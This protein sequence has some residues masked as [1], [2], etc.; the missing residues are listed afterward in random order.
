M[1][2]VKKDK[3]KKKPFKAVGR[4]AAGVG[5]SAKRP[6][7]VEKEAPCQQFCASR[8]D[9]RAWLTLI[10][11]R[12]K[13]GT[14]EEE[15]FTKAFELLTDSNPFP[16]IMGRVCPHPCEDNCNRTDKDGGVAINS[17][18]RFLG[19]WALE[20]G[21]ALKK[22]DEEKK[23]ESIGVIGAGPSGLS[24]AFQMARRGYPVT[25]YEANEIAGGML[26]YGIPEYRLPRDILQG[27]I[28]RVTD[29]GVEIKLNTKVGKDV[30]LSDLR[31]QHKVMFLAI[32]AHKG[33]SMR[34]EGEDFDGV[35]GGV[36][37]LNQVN[38]GV[39]V[40]VG[41]KVVVI[42]GGDT[43]IDAARMA[44][45][46]GADVNIVYRRT[47]VEMPAIESEIEDALKE[48]V[49]IDYLAAPVSVRQG[50]EG[51]RL[52]FKVQKMELGEPD[53]S[54]RRRPVPIE[55]SEYDLHVDTVI[56][57]ISQAPDWTPVK[58]YQPKKWLEPDPSGRIEDDTWAGG[59]VVDLGIAATA[60]FH[61]RRAAERVHTELRG[62][63][64]PPLDEL[65]SIGKD[66][67]RL[68][69]YDPL[70]R[71]ERAHRPVEEWLEKP[72]DEIDHGITK[73]QFLEEAKRCLSCGSCFGCERCWMYCTPS[74]IVK[75]E[76]QAPG[77]YYTVKL[78]LCDGC[79]KCAEE[80]PCGFW[81]MV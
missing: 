73:D 12:D 20:K 35:W 7:Q 4:G 53:S 36:E 58:E 33:K 5:G 41:K 47:R 39:K 40:N 2:I 28:D 38:R 24:F 13:T 26:Y 37:Y 30:L 64:P 54:G 11:Q 74:A 56:A 49:Q 25:V 1:P 18:E 29:V 52:T 50:T 60:V 62:M 79:N 19:D 6:K 69:L 59:D 72:N 9:V 8:T 51:T 17:M 70:D 10:A 45:R 68:D 23:D 75:L 16:S 80:C 32:G 34:I 46:D 57:A 48:G 43:A 21:V 78:E 22:L 3:K 31:K 44:R 76:K 71:T 55:G 15:A 42:G 81:E 67:L 77:S 63:E 66:K 14:P 61:G 27:E 65:Q